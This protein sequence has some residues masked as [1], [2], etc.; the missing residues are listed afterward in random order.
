MYRECLCTLHLVFSNGSILCNYSTASQP[1][2]RHWN[3]PQSYSDFTS[4][5]FAHSCVCIY[6]SVLFLSHVHGCI[7][8][9]VKV[10]TCSVIT[11]LPNTTPLQ[12]EA[13]QQHTILM[14]MRFL[15]AGHCCGPRK[16]H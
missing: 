16:Y 1:G 11:K 3:N 8:I 9:T 15:C 12:P 6:G 14:F 2:N 10:Q 7:D 4:F 5:I 13:P